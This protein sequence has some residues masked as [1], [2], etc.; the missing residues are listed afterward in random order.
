[1]WDVL[2]MAENSNRAAMKR[3]TRRLAAIMLVYVGAIFLG[4]SAKESGAL[5]GAL[6]YVAAIV[7][8]ICILAVF[9]AMGRIMIE[10]KD[11]FIRMLMVRQTLIAT[12]FA[13]GL[14]AIHGFLTIF[15]LT[16]KIDAFW[17]PTLF[18]LG[19]FVGQV[20]NRIK[21]GT[22]GTCA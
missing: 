16:E 20:A 6:L 4:V 12:A 3:Y 22:W 11:E 15:G 5:E 18:F 2:S 19:L 10:L 17:W 14:A 1:M 7:P 9:W 21:Y 8:G 13:L